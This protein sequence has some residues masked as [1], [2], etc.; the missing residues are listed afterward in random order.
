MER[1]TLP[2]ELR[3]EGRIAI[4]RRSRKYHRCSVSQEYINK[5]SHYYEIT[6]GGGGL[7]TMLFPERVKPECLEE[8]FERVRRSREL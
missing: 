8:Y 2:L 7:G 5:G 1:Q 6:I 4:L 3:R